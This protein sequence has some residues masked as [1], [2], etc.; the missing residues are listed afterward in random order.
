MPKAPASHL[1][2]PF[3]ASSMFPCY[4]PMLSRWDV[5][6]PV[7]VNLHAAF[8]FLSCLLSF[9]LAISPC[10]LIGSFLDWLCAAPL[11]ICRTSTAWRFRQGSCKACDGESNPACSS[12]IIHNTQFML[13]FTQ[14]Y[15]VN[16]IIFNIAFIIIHTHHASRFTQFDSCLLHCFH[17][18]R[19]VS[20]EFLQII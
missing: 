9:P 18:L 4:F 3:T 10:C 1:H 7:R 15:S 17:L 16:N 6:Q 19:A 11:E 2:R 12:Q 20:C 8:I 14:I 5:F 13:D